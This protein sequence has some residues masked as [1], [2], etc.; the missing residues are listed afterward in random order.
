MLRQLLPAIVGGDVGVERKLRG[1]LHGL[2]VVEDVERL[3][4][5]E[6]V[7]EDRVQ[8]RR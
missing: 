6:L 2:H 3:L 5:D 1:G 8:A 4:A 7:A